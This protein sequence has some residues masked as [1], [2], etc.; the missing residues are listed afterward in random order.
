MGEKID[1]P[2]NYEIYMNQAETYLKENALPQAIEAIEKAYEI[3]RTV[4]ANLLYVSILIQ[5]E[6]YTTAYDM[7]ADFEKLYLYEPSYASI[8]IFILLRTDQLA[9]AE[10]LIQTHEEKGLLTNEDLI[11]MKEQVQ[12]ARIELEKYQEQKK[13]ELIRKIYAIAEYTLLDQADIIQEIGIL[14]HMEIKKIEPIVMNNPYVSSYVKA[15]FLQVLIKLHYPHELVIPVLMNPVTVIPADLT[16]FNLDDLVRRLNEQLERTFEK[17][18]SLL[19]M[20]KPELNSHL[21]M[22]YPLIH[23]FITEIDYWIAL[24]AN[25]FGKELVDVD[26]TTESK[27]R[28]KSLFAQLMDENS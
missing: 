21:L 22:I 25:R 9:A 6:Q 11:N 12:E 16:E 14:D 19:L 18:P 3:E 10:K 7:T 26:E 1:F 5:A 27:K 8:F 4:E 13:E 24:Y 23:E 2:K 28:M 20:I 17:E 15:L